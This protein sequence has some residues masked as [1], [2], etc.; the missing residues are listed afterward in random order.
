MFAGDD[1]STDP[2]LAAALAAPE[3]TDRLQAVVAALTTARVLVPVVSYVE[4][5]E[6]AVEHQINGATVEVAGE[7]S[8]SAAM[9]TLAT[10]DGRSAIPVFSGMDALRAWRADARPIPAE[11]VRA[12][13]AA[14][15]D[16]DGLLVLDPGGP[17]TIP[18]PRPAVWAL[19][20]QRPW[21]P[22]VQ[23]PAVAAAIDGALA[24]VPGVAGSRVQP[25]AD[26]EVRVVLE[27]PP[28]LSRDQVRQIVQQ[29]GQALAAE[30]IVAERVDSLQFQVRPA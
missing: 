30:E 16:A 5:H 13:L 14:V 8:A 9:V 19:A 1:G 29:A 4:E 2:A 23:D 21:L 24:A 10:P 20:Q 6:E 17:V 15:A 27:L 25:G 7:K 28:G 12:A 18:V 3:G 11:G 26:A 22:A